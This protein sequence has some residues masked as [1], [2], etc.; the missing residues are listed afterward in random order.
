MPCKQELRAEAGAVVKTEEQSRR[1]VALLGLRPERIGFASRADLTI[2][3]IV[4]EVEKL[5]WLSPARLDTFTSAWRRALAELRA[6]SAELRGR[7]V[8]LCE[9]WPKSGSL[10]AI[11]VIATIVGASQDDVREVLADLVLEGR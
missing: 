2:F 7:I 9:A 10:P 6:P 8:A 11:D 1:L 4:S 3:N 5:G